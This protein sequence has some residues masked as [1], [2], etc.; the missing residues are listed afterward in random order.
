MTKKIRVLVVD[1]N[2]IIQEQISKSL[3]SDCTLISL[4]EHKQLQ[5]WI[6]DEQQ[7]VDLIFIC[8]SL[9]GASIDEFCTAWI[10]HF[11]TK[12]C[13]IVVLGADED[14]KEILALKSG[15]IQYLRKPLSNAELTKCRLKLLQN[16]RQKVSILKSQSNTDALTGL[17][18]RRYMDA[19]LQ[20]EWRRAKREGASIGVIIA[21]IDEFKLYNDQYGHAQGDICLQKVAKVLKASAKRPR[22][23]TARFGGEEFV[24]V[25]PNIDV[26]GMKVVA[27]KIREKLCLCALPHAKKAQRPLV[28]LS[29]G[30][31]WSQSAATG[32]AENLLLAADKGLYEAKSAGRDAYSKVVDIS[33]STHLCLEDVSTK[34]LF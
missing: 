34:R 1:S 22:D 31:A 18:N 30:L 28:T 27:R 23:M 24:F 21:D 26:E 5:A 12:D 10:K 2:L 17:A 6:A 20:A 25:L 4:L 16:Q 15:A 7:S 14:E 33:E 11:K 13:D 8:E 32:E 3:G 19:F 9:M 29:M